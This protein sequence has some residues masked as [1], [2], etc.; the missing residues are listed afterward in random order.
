M[1]NI[2]NAGSY[3][4]RHKALLAMAF[5]LAV[6]STIVLADDRIFRVAR[7]SLIE[8][9]VSYQRAN[10]TQKDWYD[11]THN[12]PLDVSDQIYSGPNGRAEI[13]LS[14]RNLVRIDQNSNFRISQFNTGLIQLALPIGTATFRVDSLDRRQFQVVDATDVNSDDPVYFEVDTPVV[15]ITFLKE[16]SY[17]VNVREDGTT[18]VIVRRGR[19]EVYNKE[20]GSVTIKQGRRVVIEGRDDY[21][22]IV[23]LE[24]KDGW[25]RWN[26]QRD[27][28]L[29]ARIDSYRS[30]QYV[31]VSVPGV[32]DLDVYGDW[33]QTPDYGWVWAP[34]AA[35]VGWAP[36]R[37]GYW[38][39]Y[40]S[41]GWTW[42]SN[43]P[44]GWVPYHYGRWAFWRSRWCWVPTVTVG[45]GWGN[46]WN[47][48]PHMVAFYGWGSNYRRGYRDGFNDGYWNGV[49][50]GRLGWLGWTP[51]APG[52]HF[53]AGPRVVNNNTTIVNNYPTRV[54][55]LRNFSAPGGAS[56]M[57]S[58][59]FDQGRVIVS[60][61]NL[62]VPPREVA[63]SGRTVDPRQN[64]D[65][66][67]Q[68]Q[69]LLVKPDDLKPTQQVV[70][71]RTTL[72]DRPEIT[73]RLETPVVMRK[74]APEIANPGRTVTP[75]AAAPG[76]TLNRES[77]AGDPKA[78][79]DGQVVVP[80]RT[81]KPESATPPRISDGQVVRPTRTPD[82]R[83]VERTTEPAWRSTTEGQKPAIPS[84]SADKPQRTEAPTRSEPETRRVEPPSRQPVERREAPRYEPRDTPP[85]PPREIKRQEPPPSARQPM[86]TRTVERPSS[87]PPQQAP[88]TIEK[89]A[90][91]PSAP[92]RSVEKPS[93]PPP[94]RPVK[95]EGTAPTR[96]PPD[97]N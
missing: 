44:W 2:K 34:R 36:Y 81:G 14:G 78:V 27:D 45:I 32:Y 63:S 13:Q 64:Q 58:R 76:R 75:D 37:Q 59:K 42:I 4:P 68:N 25:D 35:A 72:T 60:D 17:R 43:E 24:D 65:Q 6:L 19:A 46:G 88:R 53:Y 86:P 9:E 93:T 69:M 61:G 66:N 56:G 91:P 26:D 21:Y 80:S 83:P 12:L 90:S 89:P 28:E 54:D 97:G 48:S 38:R 82:Y 30:T 57:D 67:R 31:P 85:T 39:W 95:P 55:T 79:R 7:I 29:F 33:F 77:A 15:A 23:R 62:T 47:W 71:S 18:E 96:K 16:G 87:P 74:P 1:S 11:A 40:S 52:E 5:V 41:Y 94:S 84:R 51:L 10:D 22:Q 3:I 92:P 50:D 20:I 70:P 73:R 8:G 49:R